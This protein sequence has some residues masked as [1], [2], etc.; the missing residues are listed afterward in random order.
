MI[1][2]IITKIPEPLFIL[3]MAN[4][5]MGD[6][7]HAISLIRSFGKV[8]KKYPF[9][10]AF[11]LQYRD[12]DTFIHPEA[13]GRDDI[14]YVKRFSETR[15]TKSEFTLLIDEIRA[16]NFLA[17]ATPFDE[18]SVN[19]IEEQALDF[20]KIA[21]CS[22][23]DWPLLERVTKTNLPLIASSAGASLDEMN[24][25]ISFFQ[26]RKKDFVI[27]HCV[28]EYPTPD[29]KMHLSQIDYLKKN[30][31]G[32]RIGFSTHESPDNTDIIKMAIAK[33]ATVF[34]KHVGLP[35]D[36]YPINAYS[37]APS[38]IDAWLNAASYAFKVCGERQSRLPLNL[39]EKASL[40]SLRRGVFA[41]R[42]IKK[43]ET[44]KLEDVFFAFPPIEGNI[45][46]NEWSKH[47]IFIAEKDISENNPLTIN[48]VN[49]HDQ[50]AQILSIVTKVNNFLKKS[51][52]VVPGAADLEISHHY[53]LDK[54]NE[55]GLV[56]IT[57]VNREYCKKLLVS[58]PYQTHPEQ[59]H[60]KKEET[61]HVLSGEVH[62][63]LD[64]IVSICNPGDVIT[65]KPNVKHSWLSPTGSVIE[66]IS[67]THFKEDSFY[68]DPL[69]NER[70]S[71]KTLLTYWMS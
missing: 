47:T 66:E 51:S 22:F 30:F 39:E 25:V 1:G 9:H 65:V 8:C 67:S 23:T 26:H 38:Q 15:L 56:L 60:N 5:H 6:M 2:Q 40:N 54:F 27:L 69:I 43:G 70:K 64:G 3:E 19:L 36:I 53:G 44:I 7:D 10:F 34:E 41:R 45:S 11:K 29:E 31:D 37:A 28:G 42:S 68:T 48:N 61:F 63:T 49:R 71:R 16:N 59:Y 4:N 35:T 46:A 17:M 57:V 52:I 14:K 50:R 58:F 62:L 13:K 12:L 24:Q 55:F 32:L 18:A 33:G 20:I 21:S